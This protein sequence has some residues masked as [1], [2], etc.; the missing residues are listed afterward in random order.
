[1]TGP[2]QPKPRPLRNPKHLAHVRTLPCCVPGCNARQR[3]AHHV[4]TGGMVTKCDDSDTVPLCDPFGHHSELH[5]IGRKSFEAKYRV[6]L[7]EIA[8]DT[9]GKSPFV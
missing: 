5:R 2:Y 9:Y 1:M 6:N 3:F 4:S 7:A 8:A